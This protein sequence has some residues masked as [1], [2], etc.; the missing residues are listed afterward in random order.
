MN[1]EE[2]IYIYTSAFD[3]EWIVRNIANEA[4]CGK[5]SEE[6]HIRICNL[7]NMHYHII[8]AY[9]LN[10]YE[11]IIMAMR[12]QQ[13]WLNAWKFYCDVLDV[14]CD[15]VCLAWVVVTWFECALTLQPTSRVFLLIH[16]NEFGLVV[17][18]KVVAFE[19][20]FY[21]FLNHLNP[22]SVERVIVERVRYGL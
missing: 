1:Y 19:L 3:W 21:S 6:R 14:W 2:Y 22:S 9:V 20:S 4:R 7:H 11:C 12:H 18:I 15:L 8:F 17:F 5:I 10:M 16:I 13:W